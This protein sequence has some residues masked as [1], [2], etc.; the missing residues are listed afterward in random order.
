MTKRIFQDSIGFVA[1]GRNEGE[2]LKSALRAL[3]SICPDSP[4]VYVD[5]GST[6][7][8]VDFARSLGMMVVELDLSSPFTAARARNAG[9]EELISQHPRLEYVQFLDGDCKLHPEWPEAAMTA[10]QQYDRAA[11]VSG[12]RMEQFPEASLYNMLMDIE[13]RTPIG[14]TK[15]V[16]G[17]MCVRTDVFREVGGFNSK[18]IAAEDDDICL[19]IR[20]AG[21]RV[22]RIDAKMSEHDANIMRLGQWLKRAM[23]CGYG[24]ANIHELH[25]NGPDRYFRRELYRVLLWGGIVPLTLLVSLIVYPPLAAL[26]IAGYAL[27]VSRVAFRRFRQG[28]SPITALV[29]GALMYV[30]KVPE[31]FGVLSYWKNRF[32]SRNH[33]LIE[34]K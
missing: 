26:I 6:D 28:D 10:L 32:L 30:G 31:L 33:T 20:R 19:R 34:Y 21:Y 7:G 18:I 17:D 29:Y 14:E 27:L 15:A 8:S 24:Y 9:F 11:V 13:W 3:Q 25:G 22:Y 2:R 23:R 16:L 12:L 4:V 5:S 1:I